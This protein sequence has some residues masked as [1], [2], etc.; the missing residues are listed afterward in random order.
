ML[1]AIAGGRMLVERF[2]D[3]FDELNTYGPYLGGTRA[4]NACTQAM[5]NWLHHALS[6]NLQGFEPSPYDGICQQGVA[7]GLFERY[8]DH[9]GG[10][11]DLY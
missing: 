3:N 5:E 11:N 1:F 10:P 9:S 6:N 8:P 4:P 7:H 2:P